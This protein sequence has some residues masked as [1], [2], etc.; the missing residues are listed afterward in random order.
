MGDRMPAATWIDTAA[1]LR[2]VISALAG[3]RTWAFDTEFHR[4]KTYYPRL[5]LLQVTWSGGTVLI[6]PLAIDV[7][8]F[9]EAL[10]TGAVVVAHAADQDLEVLDRACGC[11]PTV[12]FDTQIAAGFLGQSTPSLASLVE[13]ELGLNLPKG[14]RLTDWSRRPLSAGQLSYAASDVDHLLELRERIA[15]K[16]EARGR[17]SWAEE[18][19]QRLL[20]RPRGPQDPDTAWWRLKNSRSLR[21]ASRGVAQEVAAW[22]ERRAASLDLPPRYVLA[23]LALLGIASRPPKSDKDLDDIRGLDARALKGPVRTELLEAVERGRALPPGSIRFPSAD[24]NE[25]DLRAA[26]TLAG[27]WVAQLGHDEAIDPALLATRSELTAL[28]NGR[29][30]GRVDEGWRAALVGARVRALA[31]GDAALAFDGK[32]GLLLEERSHKPVRL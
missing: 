28:L 20:E 32:G 25:R 22:R 3:E 8:P 31:A 15:A 18:E 26:I 2:D 24:D 17:L 1:G 11:A 21:G 19:C 13:R 16:L 7:A 5:A 14:D 29:P 4:E 12:L 23:D 10:T 6:D 27:A 30:A 9:A